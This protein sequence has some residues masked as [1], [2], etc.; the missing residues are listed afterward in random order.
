MVTK[1]CTQSKHL[2]MADI[3]YLGVEEEHGA[4]EVDGR[5]WPSDLRLCTGL[6]GPEV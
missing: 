3:L 1:R 6:D 2:F 4:E 5:V